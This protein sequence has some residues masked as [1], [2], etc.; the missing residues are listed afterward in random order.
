VSTLVDEKE[1]VVLKGSDVYSLK[2]ILKMRSNIK[3][4]VHNNNVM[5]KY[6]E[7]SIDESVWGLEQEDVVDA[8][9]PAFASV[10]DVDMSVVTQSLNAL[11]RGYMV[12]VAS[13][14]RAA[15]IMAGN[16]KKL[17]LGEPV[18]PFTNVLHNEWVPAYVM[19]YERCWR[20]GRKGGVYHF[21]IFGGSPTSHVIQKFFAGD[22]GAKSL[23]FLRHVFALPV[24]Q[25]ITYRTIVGMR[26]WLYLDPTVSQERGKIWVS[27]IQCNNAFKTE[28]RKILKDRTK[29]CIMEPA[30]TRWDCCDCGY[31]L[32][33]CSRATHS[34]DYVAAVCNACGKTGFFEE[35][36]EGRVCLSCQ[37]Y[38]RL[39]AGKERN[40]HGR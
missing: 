2:G 29:P 19:D 21:K 34:K 26:A 11:L 8:V 38:R 6:G 39:Q 14:D 12:T 1:E 31:G 3:D 15:W 28:N 40:S 25:H 16:Y 17:R 20:M 23:S 22:S 7:L 10:L 30:S 37:E 4:I 24:W 32:T 33:S 13:V 36:D 18:E 5:R 27:H 35:D 9:A